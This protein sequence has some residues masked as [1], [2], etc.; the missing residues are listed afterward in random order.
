MT[1]T[2]GRASA[3]RRTGGSSELRATYAA[4]Q[5]G[6]SRYI[7]TDAIGTHTCLV[8]TE[9]PGQTLNQVNGVVSVVPQGAHLRATSQQE[10]EGALGFDVAILQ[11]DDVV[12]AA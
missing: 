5:T 2:N 1:P 12:G 9:H 11:H 7:H 3:A 6:K 10:G 4:D 8:A